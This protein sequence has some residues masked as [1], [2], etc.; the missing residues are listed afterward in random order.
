MS[1]EKA[2]SFWLRTL[3]GC[4][5]H[6]PGDSRCLS[7]KS[8]NSWGLTHHLAPPSLLQGTFLPGAELLPHAH[9]PSLT[10]LS[11]AGWKWGDWRNSRDVARTVSCRS[12][13][14][15]PS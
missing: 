14:L 7:P 9:L 12:T 6:S 1:T 13:W 15:R 8:Q 4:L 11:T 2:G 10:A 3:G 5:N